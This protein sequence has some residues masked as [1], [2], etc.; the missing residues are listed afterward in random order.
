MNLK[1]MQGLTLIET[2]VA[3]TISLILLGGAITLFINNKVAYETTDNLSR[4]QE[5]ARFA[6]EFML[7]DLRMV[8]Y[9]GCRNSMDTVNNTIVTAEGDGTLEDTL[10][11]IEGIDNKGV[12]STWSPS[13]NGDTVANIVDGTDAVTI[14]HLSGSNIMV[15][16]NAGGQLTVDDATGMAVNDLVGV[17]DCGGADVFSITGLAG[18]VISH[19]PLARAYDSNGDANDPSNPMVSTFVAVRYFVGVDGNGSPSLFREVLGPGVVPVQQQLIE[20]VESMHIVYGIDTDNDN[21]PDSYVPAGDAAL[22]D[23]TEWSNVVAVRLSLLMRTTRPYGDAD[24]VGNIVYRM[25]DDTF[26]V[27]DDVINVPNDDTARRFKRRV[28]NTTVLLRNRLT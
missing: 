10:S 14:R 27:P 16:D 1:R 20:G 3:I 15:T 26:T 2:M 5:N 28:F 21:V 7:E 25:N 18:N 17:S 12:G 9:F 11:P 4:L 19:D 8:G 24:D 23:A 6:V 22:D 13:A